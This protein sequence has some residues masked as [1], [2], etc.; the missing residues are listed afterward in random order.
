[1]PGVRLDRFLASTAVV[2]LLAA[3]PGGA[4]G[5]TVTTRRSTPRLPR[6]IRRMPL[7]RHRPTAD[8]ATPQPLIA[9]PA[10]DDGIEATARQPAA[11]ATPHARQP[12]APADDCRQRRQR[13]PAHA[14]ARRSAGGARRAAT[15]DAAIADSC[16][17]SPAAN[18]TASSAARRTAPSIDAFYSGRN[19]APLWITDG[20]ANDARQGRDRLSRPCRC[21]RAR[22]R[23]LS[24]AGF[25]RAERPGRAGRS[26]AQ[27]D[28]VGHH[29]RAPCL[30]R[31]RALVARQRRHRLRPRRRRS[32]PTFS[33]RWS[34]PRTSPRRSTPTSRTRRAIWRSRPSSRKSAP[35]RATPASRR[36]RTDR[37]SRSARRTTACRNCASGSAFPATAARPTTRR[38]PTR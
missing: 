1:M 24:G 30:D 29:L 17:I 25:R 2:L 14:A 37:C 12:A 21:R 27:A 3:A 18:S 34:K 35:A 15:A 7:R 26:R 16:A 6:R 4:L 36:S 11:N 19:Y 8:K 31:A 9:E 20:K 5:G 28:D 10:G 33:P 38:S 23:R 32:R 13:P 22:S